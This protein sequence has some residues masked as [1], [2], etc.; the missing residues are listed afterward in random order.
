MVVTITVL[1]SIPVVS[2]AKTSD[3]V[4]AILSTSFQYPICQRK[5]P[6]Y[7]W[8]HHVF[9]SSTSSAAFHIVI[10][11]SSTTSW[12][13]LMKKIRCWPLQDHLSLIPLYWLSSWLVCRVDQTGCFLSGLPPAPLRQK[14]KP[15]QPAR[16]KWLWEHVHTKYSAGISE[17]FDVFYRINAVFWY[18]TGSWHGEWW[19]SG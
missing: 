10:L 17:V 11:S 8:K 9:I 19:P 4:T 13:N 16:F 2:F 14:I 18:K 5:E 3:L 12:K 7:P 1:F 15:L 6:Q